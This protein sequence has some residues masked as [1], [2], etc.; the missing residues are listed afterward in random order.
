MQTGTLEL[1]GGGT[2]TGAT[3]TSEMGATL[4]FGGSHTLDT[5]SSIGGAGTVG[6][7]ASGTIAIA[8]TYDVTGT[9][10]DDSV[11]G[12][13][14]FT[15]TI[16]SIGATLMS[17]TGT[18]NFGTNALDATTLTMTGGTLTSTADMTISG[19]ATFSSGT[20][21]GSGAVNANGGILFNIANATFTL[22][23]RTLT[24]PAGQTATW[25]GINSSIVL[26][27]GA[28]L[29]NLGMFQDQCT[30]G[31]E[32]RTSGG[33]AASFNDDGSFIKSASSS[34]GT[35]LPGVSFNV[36]SGTVDVQTGTLGLLGGGT[37][38][39][40]AFTIES[41][42]TLE[43]GGTTAFAFDSGS[44]LSGQGNL[45]KD[46]PSVLSLGGSSP[47]SPDPP[48]RTAGLGGQRIAAQQ[49]DCRQLWCHPGWFGP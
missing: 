30:A 27:D 7:T 46:G 16:T 28:V 13:V 38:T 3:F 15:G 33:A 31:H 43:F 14:N 20:I 29:D 44:T 36:T 47:P 17:Q 22:D 41:G 18:L 10:I 45:V 1:F 2:D 48:L 12:T 5:A 19:L 49:P 6:F 24:N 35:F 34:Q 8:G 26:S 39:G 11:N 32:I 37:D 40:G 21:S 42:T 23:G 25:T 4:D 9:T